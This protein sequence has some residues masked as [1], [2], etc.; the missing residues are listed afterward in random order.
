MSAYLKNIIKF[1]LFLGVGLVI[2]YRVYL[3]ADAAFQEDCLL[4]GI[5]SEE[6]VLVNKVIQDFKEANYWWVILTVILYT[7]SNISRAIRW[8]MLL[9]PLGY[10]PRYVNCFW[11]I[12]FGYFANL[13]L[14]RM[15]EIMRAGLLSQ[16]EKIEVGQVTGTVFV[17]RMIDLLAL[18]TMTA[19]AFLLAYENI[20]AFIGEYVDFGERFGGSL[21]PLLILAA[22]F[23]V[24]LLVGGILYILRRLSWVSLLIEKVRTIFF[25]FIDGIKTIRNLR[26]PFWFIFHSVNIWVMYYLMI[27]YCF[28][29]FEPTSG[30]SGVA[31]LFIFVLG[32]WG[33]VIPSPG[34]MGTYHFMVQT[35]LSMYGIS[36]D[37][38]FSFANIAF[39]SIQL[40]ANVFLGLL[41]LLVLP[42]I[43]KNYTPKPRLE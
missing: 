19:L 10:R 21:G 1:L 41:A 31:G 5:P 14:P 17:S 24:L 2:L 11:A 42:W 7:I 16:Y 4:K 15:G 26:R 8:R 28:F 40:G 13:G 3:S 18:L 30:L 43:N 32:G 20:N 9:E 25:G 12:A 34:G 27:Y 6:C 36:W 23:G 37:D 22:G 38:G 39:F 29:S 35:G 33:M